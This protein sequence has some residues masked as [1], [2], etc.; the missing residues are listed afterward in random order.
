M[1]QNKPP[2]GSDQFALRL[3]EGMRERIRQAADKNGRS[4]NAELLATLAAAYPAP[5]PDLE[6]ILAE[7]Q[8]AQSPSDF[9]NRARA[10]NEKLSAAGSPY[11]VDMVPP[12]PGKIALSTAPQVPVPAEG[13]TVILS[14]RTVPKP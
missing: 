11:R 8:E 13:Q 5:A 3:P 2:R 1:A 14:G 9:A 12:F 10:A 7:L 4:M 6:S